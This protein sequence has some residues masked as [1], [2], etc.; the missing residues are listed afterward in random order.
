V[1]G[2]AVCSAAS[3]VRRCRVVRAMPC[4]R[5]AAVPCCGAVLPR[6]RRC[7]LSAGAALSE[8]AAL[9]APVG[10]RRARCRHRARGIPRP[11]FDG[12]G[13]LPIRVSLAQPPPPARPVRPLRL[14]G[15]RGAAA[16]A[17][18]R[19]VIGCLSPV[20]GG[21]CGSG[22]FFRSLR[23]GGQG[24]RGAHSPAHSSR[25]PR[26][27]FGRRRACR[28]R[29]SALPNRD[30]L[31]CVMAFCDRVDNPLSP[32]DPYVC[33]LAPF[34]HTVSIAQSVREEE[35]GALMKALETVADRHLRSQEPYGRTVTHGV[36]ALSN[37]TR[38]STTRSNAPA[39]ADALRGD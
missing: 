21:I 6:C 14:G 36:L 34:H 25:I 9:S 31:R 22:R 15:N 19:C 33:H 23:E 4:C 26:A 27:F 24:G 17:P 30:S 38:R 16:S 35:V 37:G 39:G 32:L 3:C 18:S 11:R 13:C 5:G 28:L 20:V 29:A 10:R 7:P 2:G 8:G 1:F 12:C